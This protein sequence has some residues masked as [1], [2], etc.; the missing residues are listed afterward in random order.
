MNGSGDSEGENK[1]T[2]DDAQCDAEEID[3]NMLAQVNAEID[4][5]GEVEG[6]L[7]QLNA[8][9]LTELSSMVDQGFNGLA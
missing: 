5:L 7:S 9:Q 6:L 8:E 2:C 4:D 1:T 3:E